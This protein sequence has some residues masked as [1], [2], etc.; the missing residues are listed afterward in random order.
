MKMNQNL[1]Y[2]VFP[3]SKVWILYTDHKLKLK[4][5]YPSNLISHEGFIHL[6]PVPI[7]CLQGLQLTD[8]WH[9][10]FSPGTDHRSISLSCHHPDVCLA[11]HSWSR[12]KVDRQTALQLCLWGLQS[13][14]TERL[15]GRHSQHQSHVISL[16]SL[17]DLIYKILGVLRRQ[18]RTSLLAQL[19]YS[20]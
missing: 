10:S 11:L 4:F 9:C 14:A 5:K 1:D 2:H 12:E 8:A 3:L 17:C 7:H 18:R 6:A 15:A 16:A 19:L 20:L 13:P